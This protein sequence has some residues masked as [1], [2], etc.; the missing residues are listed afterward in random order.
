M[1]LKVL[2]AKGAT[3]LIEKEKIARHYFYTW[4]ED[5]KRIS[6]KGMHCFKSF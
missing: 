1:V 5:S 3:L 2:R 6:E 4:K